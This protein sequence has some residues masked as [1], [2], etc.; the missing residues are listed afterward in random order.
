VKKKTLAFVL[1]SMIMVSSAFALPWKSGQGEMDLVIPGQRTDLHYRLY[2]Y[3]INGKGIF[4]GLADAMD[5]SFNTVD[6]FH[7]FSDGAKAWYIDIPVGVAASVEIEGIN[8]AGTVVIGFDDGAGE[9]RHMF[10]RI[11]FSKWIKPLVN[12]LPVR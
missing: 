12:G 8:E 7:F 3:G 1:A 6:Y 11:G 10:L 2:I 5:A 9:F 4:W